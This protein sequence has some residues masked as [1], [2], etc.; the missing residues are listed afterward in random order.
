[1]LTKL[2]QA[3][4]PLKQLPQFGQSPW[5][6]NIERGLI[7]NGGLKELIADFGILGVTT[8][9]SIFEKAIINSSA[10]DGQISE[11]AGKGKSVLEIYDELIISDVRE[12]ADLFR[13]IYLASNRTDGYISIE[14]LPEFAHDVEKTINHAE[15]TFKRVNRENIMIKVPA[16]IESPEAISA[17]ISDGINVNVTLIFSKAHY[18]T[19]AKA[20]IEGVK[21]ALNKNKDI[22]KICSV[23]SVFVSRVDTK[24]D[25]ILDELLKNNHPDTQLIKSLKGK[26]AIAN[27][28]IIY[29]VF[30]KIFAEADFGGLKNKGAK[31]QRVLWGS[32]STKNPLF[33]DVKYVE[34]LIG[35][36]TIN[37][38]APETVKAFKDHGKPSFSLEEEL[39]EA[40]KALQDLKTLGINLDS[41][42]QEIQNAG[43]KAFQDSFNNLIAAIREKAA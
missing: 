32:T 28:K 22:S 23:A 27:C 5:Y 35:P 8:N 24:I 2:S 13:D 30:K 9:P 15:D 10:Y 16:T 11:L 21:K 19:I 14:V 25:L 18:E 17:L 20:Y 41:V 26:I 12:A 33:S 6:D 31:A 34:K 39:D 36:D 4:N 29:Q 38:I 3:T 40:E 42:C 7:K 1:M 37:T 43:V